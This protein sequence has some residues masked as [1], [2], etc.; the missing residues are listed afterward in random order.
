MTV[1]GGNAVL[2]DRASGSGEK[3]SGARLD[4]QR[5]A[6]PRLAR[7]PAKAQHAGR[8][9]RHA[10]DLVELRLVS[11][12]ADP[13][14]RPIFVDQHLGESFSRTVEVFAQVLINEYRP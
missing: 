5:P 4:R 14:A 7:P 11:M 12:P 9:Q 10:D 6:L 2:P 13:G 8:K 1:D 3:I